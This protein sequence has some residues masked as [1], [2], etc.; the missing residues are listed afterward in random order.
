MYLKRIEAIGFKSFAEKTIIEFEEG[1]TAI[2]GPN[3]SGKS[4]ISD[5]IK[6]VLGEQ[7]SK[8]LRGKVM[9]DV[10]FAGTTN[11]SPLNVAE[12]TLVLDNTDQ[13]LP[14][15][16]EEVA[17]TRRLFRSG[18]SQY[19]LN[20]QKVRLKDVRELIMDSGIGADSLS[21]ISQDKVRHIVEAKPEERRVVIE[22]AAGVL[23]YK[24][25]KKEAERN[26]EHTQS[27]LQRIDDIMHELE[28][29][30]GPLEK[31][32]KIAEEYLEKKS[33]L[34]GIEVALYVKEIDQAVK[35][36]KE[37][38]KEIQENSI[39][40]FNY[41][42]MEK[43]NTEEIDVLS[44]EKNK[45]EEQ[46]SHYQDLAMEINSKISYI[47]GQRKALMGSSENDVDD[48]EA[49]ENRFKENLRQ[50]EKQQ[51]ELRELQDDLPELINKRKEFQTQV[52]DLQEQLNR[53]NSE[54]YGL[55]S[56]IKVLNDFSN[57]YYKG[58]KSV[59][60]A[61]ERNQL[62]GIYG[63][64]DSLI[65]TEDSYVEAIELALQAAMQHIIVE[66]VADAKQAIKY[67]KQ[68][69]AGVATFLPLD[70]IKPRS[71]RSD[72]MKQIVSAP[73]F[74]DLAVNLITFDSKYQNVMENLLGNII[75]ADNIDNAT[76]LSKLINNSYRIITLDG[77]II[78][79]GGSM[80]GGKTNRKRTGLLQQRLE[81][82]EAHQRL[83]QAK[84][85]ISPL[86]RQISE[87]ANKFK[88]LDELI[89][90][91]RMNHARLEEYLRNKASTIKSLKLSME[92][93]NTKQMLEEREQYNEKIREIRKENVKLLETIKHYERE[94]NEINRFIRN[95][96]NELR[97]LDVEKNRI[98]VKY[99][100]NLDFLQNEYRVTYE[101]AKN[102]YKL[103]ME[104]EIARI[105]SK[106]L[107]KYLDSLGPV[108]LAAVDEFKRVKDRYEKFKENHEDLVTARKNILS[109]IS[110]LDEV[111]IE[112]FKDTFD[113]VKDEFTEVFRTL[114]NGGSAELLLTDE[115]DL[116][117]TGVEIIARPPGTKLRNS[118]LLS[119]GQKTLT[120]ISLLFAI[121]RIR[122]VP[123]CVLDEVEAA[124]DEA[125]VNRY[126]DYLVQFS[127]QT[128]FI[129]ITHRK[130]TMEKADTLYGITMQESGVTTVVSVRFDET[131]EFI[132]ENVAS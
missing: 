18:E 76:K 90:K 45:L 3:G 112:K 63:T 78:H 59:V 75:I 38:E 52:S 120:A 51:E 31:Q 5:A 98:D 68:N 55:E 121:L 49:F 34:E 108:N 65:N 54:C 104:F 20:K 17:I 124:L 87:Y 106:K 30:K 132:D 62:K 19:L 57:A 92:Q 67:L 130:G 125:N 89:S 114:F 123:F 8:S 32:A 127:K 43:K 39:Q 47:E 66:Q 12:I 41:E 77:E 2:V 44:K 23:K 107:R 110:E 86:K 60:T 24:N 101:Y 1:V 6:W 21:I 80:T 126:A 22:E 9:S 91:K 115:N 131:E 83:E 70:V 111:M 100:N 46:I 93:D 85:D 14:V 35:R 113:K 73:G 79:V 28:S 117:N 105:K 29:Q 37:I 128:Q 99:N 119:G 88:E 102:N 69:N 97:N 48:K 25:R 122:T 95:V 116:L 50:Y 84:G 71:V 7:S 40:V 74:V 61:K 56:K 27:N 82:E 81:L 36:I 10:I 72:V 33:E 103:D 118:S 15:D 13:S 96:N 58:V 94:N 16:Y 42:K 64:V 26:L 4:N 11:R 129:V 109:S 53:K